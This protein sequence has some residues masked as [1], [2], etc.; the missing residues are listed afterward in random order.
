VLSETSP[1]L[2]ELVKAKK[3]TIRAALYDVGNGKVT[4]IEA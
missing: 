2:A 4:M 3:L 1:V